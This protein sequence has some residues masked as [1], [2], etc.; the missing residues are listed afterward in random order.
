MQPIMYRASVSPFLMMLANLSAILKKAAAHAE[1]R[2]IE[3]GVL[4][5][6]RLFP[7]MFPLSK[8]VQIGSDFAKRASARLAGVEPPPYEDK[9]S[10]FDD[11]QARVAK[12]VEFIR[13]LRPEQFESAETRMISVPMPNETRTMSGAAY[14]FDYALP[15]FFFH[16]TTAYDILRH[17]GVDLG[18]VDYVT[19]PGRE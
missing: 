3:P 5:N 11:L 9:E 18:K 19:V 6:A 10:T 2:K 12:T 8:Q 14:L 7:D 17:N 13:T 1:A 16:V 4:V 15:N